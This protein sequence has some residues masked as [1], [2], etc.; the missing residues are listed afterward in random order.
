MPVMTALAFK[1][2]AL[3]N[4]LLQRMQ[5]EEEATIFEEVKP[6]MENSPIDRI[7]FVMQ[8]LLKLAVLLDSGDEIGR[9][10]L[11]ALISKSILR[12]IVSATITL[13]WFFRDNV[14]SRYAS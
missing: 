14:F 5:T 1:I 4:E 2:Q 7:V 10:R 12:N 6:V 8:E 9:R 3:Y 13:I 11:F